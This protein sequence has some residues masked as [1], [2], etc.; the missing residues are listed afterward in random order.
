M[1]STPEILSRLKLLSHIQKG[2]KLGSKTMTLQADTWYTRL[3]RTWVSPDNRQNTLKLIREVVSRAFEILLHAIGST[4]ES[5]VFQCRSIV[6]DLH[7]CQT[8]L[9]NLKATYSEDIKFGCDM[10]ILLQQIAARLSEIRKGYPSLFEP[11]PLE[12]VIEC[13]DPGLQIASSSPK[14]ISPQF[15]PSSGSSLS[16]LQVA[17]STGDKGDL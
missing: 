9:H 10:D 4:K 8:G 17:T 11:N 15:G 1:E 5:D 13:K 7:K 14:Q 3:V 12:Q 2:E 16:P 6:T